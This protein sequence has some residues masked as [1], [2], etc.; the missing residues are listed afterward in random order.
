M[1][2]N[3]EKSLHNICRKCG[4]SKFKDWNELTSDE[5]F[6][7]E[8]ISPEKFSGEEGKKYRFC[9]RCFYADESAE[10]NRA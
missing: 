4:S 1:E 6:I 9:A 5:K 2:R 7:A 3:D 10:E 8:R